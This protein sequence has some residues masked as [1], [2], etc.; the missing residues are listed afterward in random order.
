MSW[1]LRFT[2]RETASTNLGAPK[3]HEKREVFV[4][5]DLV[6]LF[7]AWWGECGKPA[8]DTVVYRARRRPA[9]STRR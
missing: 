7:G 9:T 8:D 6:D 1:S 5:K 2:T 3:N 4:T